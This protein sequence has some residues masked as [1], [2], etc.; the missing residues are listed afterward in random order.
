MTVIITAK[1]GNRV[2]AGARENVWVKQRNLVAYMKEHGCLHHLVLD[3]E[4]E[5]WLMEEW[6]SAEVF[7]H[8]FD[9]NAGFR[10]ALRE[11]GFREFP[12]NVKLWRPIESEDESRR[13]GAADRSSNIAL[14]EA[15]RRL[16]PTHPARSASPPVAGRFPAP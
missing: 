15:V 16:L 12:D 9:G 3:L 4:D 7:E 5:A 11:A 2:A 6:E 14:T 1:L 10:R 13:I 8:F